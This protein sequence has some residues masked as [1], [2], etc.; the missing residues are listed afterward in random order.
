MVKKD[1]KIDLKSNLYSHFSF[2]MRRIGLDSHFSLR[3][4]DFLA[5]SSK[6]ECL[7]FYF[8]VRV[9]EF[10][11]LRIRRVGL[12]SYFSFI[13]RKIKFHLG[14]YLQNYTDLESIYIF[15]FN[16]SGLMSYE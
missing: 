13:M 8:L 1:N 11:L 4:K 6:F 7:K 3:E 2:I 5:F 10:T 15:F 12:D 14:R 9:L 16:I